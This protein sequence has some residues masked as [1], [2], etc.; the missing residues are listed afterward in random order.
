M[1]GRG[2]VG[3]WQRTSIPDSMSA[4]AGGRAAP[5]TPRL[6]SRSATWARVRLR[7]CC[8]SGDLASASGFAFSVF[9][10]ASSFF[11]TA[12]TRASPPRSR[13][14]S[15]SSSSSSSSSGTSSSSSVR[16]SDAAYFA[17]G[18]SAISPPEGSFISA[19]APRTRSRARETAEASL[20]FPRVAERS[21]N[22]FFAA[23][24]RA[25]SADE[26]EASIA[27]RCSSAWR[28]ISRT[29]RPSEAVRSSE[30]GAAFAACEAWDAPP[31]AALSFFSTLRSV[32]I[33]SAS[34][35]SSG[36]E[37]TFALSLRYR[38]SSAAGEA[39]SR[40]SS[41]AGSSSV[42]SI[43]WRDGVRSRLWGAS[44]SPIERFSA[45]RRWR[46]AV[47]FDFSADDICDSWP[48]SFFRRSSSVRTV[49]ASSRAAAT[50][51]A[52]ARSSALIIFLAESTKPADARKSCLVWSTGRRRTSAVAAKI[53]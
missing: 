41:C 53:S 1:R 30:A 28:M 12:P 38:D 13:S 11:T 18:A 15:S 45:E 43:W 52:H 3:G 48:S 26:P 10:A 23:R 2:A 7:S 33:T 31:D 5:S 25:R 46:I 22:C 51:K 20:D 34:S 44:S 17:R 19:T 6:A 47:S 35:F 21:A 40:S 50:A 42:A 32:L 8:S 4:P 9:T 29:V 49:A 14:A 16:S 24:A 27:P 36:V 39:A 37:S